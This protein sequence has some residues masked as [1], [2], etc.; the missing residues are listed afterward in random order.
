[1]APGVAPS[2]GG[3]ASAM[4]VAPHD[5]PDVA[6]TSALASA[7]ALATAADGSFGF[8]VNFSP[9]HGAPHPGNLCIVCCGPQQG[10][11]SQLVQVVGWGW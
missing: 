3:N 11:V 10:R 7:L 8:A 6:A 9:F 5:A 2:A 1:M 4:G